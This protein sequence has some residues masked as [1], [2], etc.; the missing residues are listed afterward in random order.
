MKQI[1][2]CYYVATYKLVHQFQ[3]N[4]PFLITS[5]GVDIIEGSYCW[6]HEYPSEKKFE[7][8]NIP[9]N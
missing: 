7:T 1:L 8:L 2:L 5:R 4:N 3:D 9:P 6:F